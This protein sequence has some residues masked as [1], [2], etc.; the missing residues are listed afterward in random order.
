MKKEGIRCRL[1]EGKIGRL[2]FRCRVVKDAI[3]SLS[4]S[5]DLLNWHL[6]NRDH[7]LRGPRVR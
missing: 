3:A 4:L 2:D 6:V 7:G 1:E 5:I